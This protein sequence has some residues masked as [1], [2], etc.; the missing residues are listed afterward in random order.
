MTTLA[1]VLNF[2]D[3][4]KYFWLAFHLSTMLINSETTSIEPE[5]THEYCL[6]LFRYSQAS[7]MAQMAI[8]FCRVVQPQQQTLTSQQHILQAEILISLVTLE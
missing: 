8:P 6:R 7:M 1:Y 3:I 4:D 2:I 5:Q